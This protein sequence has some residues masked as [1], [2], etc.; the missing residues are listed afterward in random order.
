MVVLSPTPRPS[1]GRGAPDQE[2]RSTL[3]VLRQALAHPMASYWLILV[4]TGL[5]LALG[6]MMVLSASSVLGLA[7]Y[8]DAYYFVKRQV[9]F[10]GVGLVAMWALSRRPV[11]QLRVLAWVSWFASVV[12]LLMLF[13]PLGV[14]VNGNTNW[15]SIPGLSFF[16]IQPSE[17]AKL[18][19]V[20]WSADVLARKE[21]LLD[22]PRH[23]LIPFLPMVGALVGLTL[24]GGDLGTAVVMGAIVLA[25]LWMVGTP[26]RVL[27]VLG[28]AAAAGVA[29]MVL[30]S[31]NRIRRLVSFLNPTVDTEGVAMQPTLG[32]WAL[33]SG[34]WWGLGLGKSRQ[35]F[36]GL[37]EAHTDFVFAIIGE[38]MGLVGTLT[39]LAL[40]MVL[41]YAGLRVALRSDSTFCS[42]LAAGTTAWFASQAL[43]NLG[44]VLRLLPVM[45]V[46]LPFVSYGGSAMLANLAALG[47]LLACA[48]HEPAARAL[49]ARRRGTPRPR[50]TAVI[51]SRRR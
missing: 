16:N 34:G 48:R 11:P 43:I 13:T 2:G 14:D 26:I 4:S 42:M 38:E 23:L 32:V 49:L 18:S 22:Q 19:I 35:K 31:P 45:G 41:G 36:G 33:A 12:L 10:L 37:V 1:D 47:L 6:T 29:A 28:L 8:D 5:L 15:V 44:V 27:A 25:I 39:V 46:P 17:M 3:A 20:L 7:E 9:V 24:L 51:G 30:T 21:P 40:F 50:M